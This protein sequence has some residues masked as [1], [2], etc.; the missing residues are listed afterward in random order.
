MLLNQIKA[1][2]YER[3]LKEG[4]THNFSLALPAHLAEQAEEA[5]KSSFILG[6]NEYFIDLL[7]YHRFLKTLVA[8]ELKV[9]A[10]EPE[11]AGKMDFYLNLLNEKERAADDQP[12]IGIILCAEKDDVDE[13][14]WGGRVQ[15]HG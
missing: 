8:V 13:P 15:A 9:G 12:S 6:K 14:Y 3:S 2:A 4:K 1:A 10:F 11:F 7:F 5:L